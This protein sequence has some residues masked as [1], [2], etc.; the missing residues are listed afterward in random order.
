MANKYKDP[1][2][3]CILDICNPD[4]ISK[5]PNNNNDVDDSIDDVNFNLQ[6]M[7]NIISGLEKVT[8][9]NNNTNNFSN[10]KNN[11]IEDDHNFIPTKNNLSYSSDDNSSDT[12]SSS[13]SSKSS[14]LSI[15]HNNSNNSNINSN[16]GR[17]ITLNDINNNYDKL[18]YTNINSNNN[19]NTNNIDN[20]IIPNKT[21]RTE[22]LNRAKYL[23]DIL[24]SDS[25]DVSGL[26]Y[27]DI[28]IDDETLTELLDY[29]EYRNDV[30]N[31]ATFITETINCL[32]TVATSIFDGRMTILGVNADLTGW[33][34][35]VETKMRRMRYQASEVASGIVKTFKLKGIF[36]ILI[37]LIPSAAL[38]IRQNNRNKVEKGINYNNDYYDSMNNLDDDNDKK[39]NNMEN[40]VSNDDNNDDSDTDSNYSDVD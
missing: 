37:E 13:R 24:K 29:L 32:V 6:Q 4:K 38:Q 18:R 22:K 16:I 31:G 3:N 12:S 28:S 40:G 25:I 5:K 35:K 27:P 7:N 15:K 36:R 2:V 8:L 17:G 19:T 33:D 26:P 11:Y 23:Y 20:K 21:N 1:T 14:I 10:N 30:E 39:I 9:S 34:R